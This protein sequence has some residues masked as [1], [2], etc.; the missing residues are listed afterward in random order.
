LHKEKPEMLWIVE[1]GSGCG[2]EQ[3]RSL[4]FYIYRETRQPGIIMEGLI[5]L[6]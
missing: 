3:L 2:K 1:E 5:Q 4:C 6:G